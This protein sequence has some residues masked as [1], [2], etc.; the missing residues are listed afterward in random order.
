MTLFSLVFTA[1]FLCFLIAAIVGHALLIEAA[2]RPFFARL[3]LP[4]VPARIRA[5]SAR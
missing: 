1:L 5:L 4:P 3:P 2:L